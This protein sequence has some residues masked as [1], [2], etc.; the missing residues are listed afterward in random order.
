M[1]LIDIKKYDFD[2]EID[3]R[4]AKKNNITGRKI[5]KEEK[6]LLIK[7]AAEKIFLASKI[8]KTFNCNLK[9]FE[10]TDRVQE[11]LGNFA[12]IRI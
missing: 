1:T 7:E 12:L 5:F 6:C 10:H 9:I 4:Y 2:I 3:L 8:A 11:A